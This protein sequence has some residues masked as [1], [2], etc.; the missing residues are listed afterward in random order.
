MFPEPANEW[1]DGALP[2]EW[3]SKLYGHS[4]PRLH[5]SPGDANS[6]GRQ[7]IQSHIRKS[8]L[9]ALD[10]SCTVL[11]QSFL[12]SLFSLSLS[13][14]FRPMVHLISI[15]SLSLCVVFSLSLFS[16]YFSLF[17]SLFVLFVS[18]SVSLIF[19]PSPCSLYTVFS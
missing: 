8:S 2:R 4:L 5:Y 19:H 3:R 16:L 14:S 13:L 18:C 6:S 1:A 10:P 11:C 12:S 7:I 15:P 9:R 17:L